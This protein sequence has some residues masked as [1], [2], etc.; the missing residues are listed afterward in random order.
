MLQSRRKHAV[1][2]RLHQGYLSPLIKTNIS[3]SM[4]E[5]PGGKVIMP[6]CALPAMLWYSVKDSESRPAKSRSNSM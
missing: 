4:Q 1:V 5:A 2:R 6:R 3:R